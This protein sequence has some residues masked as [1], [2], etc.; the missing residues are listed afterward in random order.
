MTSS[1]NI[2]TRDKELDSLSPESPS[3]LG[4]GCVDA[5]TT[6]SRRHRWLVA[7]RCVQVFCL[8]LFV[9]PLTVSGW[10][11]FGGTVGG[12][13]SLPTPAELPFYGSLS[14]S[15]LVDINILDPFAALQVLL[16]AK[17]P[18]LDLLIFSL[19]V[20]IVYGLIR[21]RAFCGWVC[22]VNFILEGFDFVRKKLGIKVIEGK[23][24][25][26]TKIV[27][28]LVVLV[29]TVITSIPIFEAVSPISLVNKGILFGSIAGLVTFIAIVVTELFWGHRVW[30]RAICPVGGFYQVLGRLGF[31]NVR[32][33]RDACIHCNLCKVKCLADPAI[34]DPVLTGRSNT[35]LAGDCMLCG[36][37]VDVCPTKALSVHTGLDHYHK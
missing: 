10:T 2:D 23:P 37:C 3:S 33:E 14:S 31:V 12:D 15:S 11:L 34:L 21:G 16:A 20:L 32:F 27:V 26:H 18:M 30:C 17:D 5:P 22:P 9:L 13:D 25:R 4:E 29:L 1:S 6:G 8:L 24:P 36:A 7:R 28:A 35:V 19:P